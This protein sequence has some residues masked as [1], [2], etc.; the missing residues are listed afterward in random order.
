MTA[1]I[2]ALEPVPQYSEDVSVGYDAYEAFRRLVRVVARP[3]V[4]HRC[5]R[6]RAP[7]DRPVRDRQ[8]PHPLHHASRCG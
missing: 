1:V 5:E 4:Q 8:L 7:A 6:A 2:W 3:V